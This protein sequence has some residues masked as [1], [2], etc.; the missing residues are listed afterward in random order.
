MPLPG[1]SLLVLRPKSHEGFLK[2]GCKFVVI[3]KNK[4]KKDVHMFIWPMLLMPSDPFSSTDYLFE[5]KSD[6]IRL[7]LIH[8]KG[9]E[10]R[11]YTRHRT[12]CTKQFIELQDLSFSEDVILDGE[13]ICFDPK[14]G[15]ED[16]ELVMRRFQT[17]SSEKI[18]ALSREI[19]CTYMVF[20]ILY[21]KKPL[22]NL[23]LMER[24][25]I[26]NEI[27]SPSESVQ[28]VDYIE[29]HGEAFFSSIK[30]MQLEGCVAK[31]KN[32][33]YYPGKRTPEWL[34]IIR[35][36]YYEVIITGMRKKEFG[37]LCSFIT[38]NGLKPAGIIEFATAKQRKEIYH[39]AK[40]DG[41]DR[42]NVYFSPS[43][44][45]KVK[46]RGRTSKGFYEHPL[47]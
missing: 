13:I 18:L 41:E 2:N 14:K 16:L 25:H 22:V 19:P 6:G 40:K 23:P 38:E 34:K 35:Y 31:R 20:D 26:L 1:Y 24:K 42:L 10:N 9:K 46:T 43:V 30:E 36:E 44:K 3:T 21:Y 32:G 27:L 5:W 7:E 15:K 39:L 17:T 37:Y 47:F 12:D 28:K 4:K 29:D 11:C 45:C 33:L 8:Q